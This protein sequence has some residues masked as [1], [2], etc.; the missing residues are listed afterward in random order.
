MK[1]Q[2]RFV[3]SYVFIITLLV[4]GVFT[5][6]LAIVTDELAGDTSSFLASLI[7][8][9]NFLAAVVFFVGAAFIY[10]LTVLINQ[11]FQTQLSVD[12]I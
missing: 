6:I 12:D 8:Q 1:Y 4:L 11:N 7:G 2:R 10:C 3:F 5:L 9:K